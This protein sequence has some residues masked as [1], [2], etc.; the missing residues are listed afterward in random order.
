MT[1]YTIYSVLALTLGLA[2][3]KEYLNRKNNPTTEQQV[4]KFEVTTN[5]GVQPVDATQTVNKPP[6]LLPSDKSDSNIP[7]LPVTEP[8]AETQTLSKPIVA[9]PVVEPIKIPLSPKTGS[10]YDVA[11]PKKDTEVKIT[12][13][14]SLPAADPTAAKA[15][16]RPALQDLEGKSVLVK[17]EDSSTKPSDPQTVVVNRQPVPV[18]PTYPSNPGGLNI[19]TGQFQQP[20]TPYDQQPRQPSGMNVDLGLGAFVTYEQMRNPDIVKKDSQRSDRTLRDAQLFYRAY[21]NKSVED[22]YRLQGSELSLQDLF[23]FRTDAKSRFELIRAYWKL[24]I[25]MADFHWA[26]DEFRT[27]QKLGE[28]RNSGN[29]NS[30]K[31][32]TAIVYASMC[33]FLDAETAVI[34]AQYE[35]MGLMGNTRRRPLAIDVPLVGTYNTRLATLYPNVRTAP[36]RLLII[37]STIDKKRDTINLRALAMATTY[38][39]WFDAQG[40]YFSNPQEQGAQVVGLAYDQLVRHRRAFLDSIRNYNTDIAEYVLLTNQASVRPDELTQSLIR[41]PSRPLWNTTADASETRNNVMR[42]PAIIEDHAVQPATFSEATDGQD[43][44]RKDPANL[45][46]S[47]MT[48]ISESRDR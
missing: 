26:Y 7:K 22:R 4:N 3:V 35:L 8:A 20:V 28:V 44:T 21:D 32:F 42:Q 34:N 6:L 39:A 38:D 36:Q 14:D 46:P 5:P 48:K 41:N 11:I 15:G 12:S 17:L 27:M 25:A 24:A 47:V 29:T 33:R 13:F 19:P 31:I 37:D 10:A 45:P 16:E 43:Y 2:G 1:K 40:S 30:H 18:G 9:Q 23:M